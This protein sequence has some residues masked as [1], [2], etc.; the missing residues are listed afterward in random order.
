MSAASRVHAELASLRSTYCDKIFNLSVV[1][2]NP[3]CHLR[4][5]GAPYN[6]TTIWSKLTD[7]ISELDGMVINQLGVYLECL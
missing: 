4:Y 2:K 1:L 6:A 7:L 5:V 3:E